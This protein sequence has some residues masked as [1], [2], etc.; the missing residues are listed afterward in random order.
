MTPWETQGALQWDGV[1]MP[2][3]LGPAVIITLTAGLHAED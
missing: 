3:M 1:K 2:G